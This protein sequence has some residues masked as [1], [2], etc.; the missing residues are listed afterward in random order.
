MTEP[1]NDFPKQLVEFSRE[2]NR[3]RVGAVVSVANDEAF[4]RVNLSDGTEVWR[5]LVS[6]DNVRKHLATLLVG[7]NVVFQISGNYLRH[8]RKI[9]QNE[10]ESILDGQQIEAWKQESPTSVLTA[11]VAPNVIERLREYARAR[12]LTMDDTVSQLLTEG[13]YDAGY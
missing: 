4:I 10:L 12:R 11:L 5:L 1:E 13:L 7:D 3:K 9:D 8:I 2:I 6:R